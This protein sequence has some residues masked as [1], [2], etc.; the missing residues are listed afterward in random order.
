MH[1][2]ITELETTKLVKI[3]EKDRKILSLLSENSR[4]PL[5][6]LTKAVKLSRDAVDYRI[7]RL[8]GKGVIV[9]FFPVIDFKKFE[10]N[11]YHVFFNIDESNPAKLKV[12]HEELE[13][14]PNVYSVIVYS[15]TWDLE[16]VFAAKSL[17]EFDDVLT[18]LSTKYADLIL[19]KSILETIHSYASV[20]LPK[21]ITKKQTELFKKKKK[22]EKA[23]IDDKDLAILKLLSEDARM[24]SYDIAGKVKLSADAVSYRIKKL[25]DS[26]VILKFTILVDFS[27]LNYHWYTFVFSVKIFDNKTEA[28]FR[29]FVQ[30]HP[31]IIEAKKT[32]GVWDLM[33][34]IVVDTHRK[35]H[36]AIKQFKAEFS[37]ILR[38]DQTWIAYQEQVF[39]PFPA[40]LEK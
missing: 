30:T 1:G 20:F 31:Y 9:R 17:E 28:K 22:E 3:D 11:L 37:D 15:D 14:H 19:E 8:I 2:R 4:I 39:N 32:L 5:T 25:V 35:F 18:E 16:I 38:T 12:M 6:Q 34:Y 13:S 27:Y 26:E 29:Q 21:D 10:Y 36:E 7:K 40:C 24:S 33:F 23:S